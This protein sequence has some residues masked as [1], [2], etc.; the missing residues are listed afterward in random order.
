M[1]STSRVIPG[2]RLRFM[3]S[4][5]C[6]QPYLNTF[7]C[8]RLLRPNVSKGEEEAVLLRF[9]LTLLSSKA[10]QFIYSGHKLMIQRD[11]NIS[12]WRFDLS[13]FRACKLSVEEL[14]FFFSLFLF[15]LLALTSHHTLSPHSKLYIN[16]VSIATQGV[17]V[18]VQAV[19]LVLK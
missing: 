10:S 14:L 3:A 15:Q 18:A 4:D 9:K 2:F 13:I 6:K 16:A 12:T 1:T 11:C 8:M 19:K 17:L 5:V 7:S